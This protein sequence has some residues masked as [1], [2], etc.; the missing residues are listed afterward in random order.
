MNEPLP[1]NSKKLSK[2]TGQSSLSV[3]KRK[4]ILVKKRQLHINQQAE[5]IEMSFK[6]GQPLTL[7]IVH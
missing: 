7:N 6:M 4:E 3:W 2:V 5:A 1:A